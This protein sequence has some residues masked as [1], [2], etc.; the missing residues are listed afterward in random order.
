MSAGCA[1]DLD[2]FALERLSPCPFT[3]EAAPLE[4]AHGDK[5]EAQRSEQQKEHEG[6]ALGRREEDGEAEQREVDE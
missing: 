3:I 1:A 2:E 6:L 4:P 5:H